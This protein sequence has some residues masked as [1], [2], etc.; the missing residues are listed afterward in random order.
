MKYLLKQTIIPIVYLIFM[1]IIA[2]GILCL[3]N[4]LTWLKIILSILNLA[5]YGFIVG[6]V[7]KKEGEDALKVRIANDVERLQIIRTGEDRP[8][9]LKEEYKAWKG[10]VVGLIVCAPLIILL[11]FHVIL[12]SINPDLVGAGVIANFIYLS[13]GAF[14]RIDNTISLMDW[15]Y[16]F[17]L[18]AVLILPLITGIPYI[19]GA[20]KIKLQQ[21]MILQKQRQIYGDDYGR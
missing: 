2:F 3:G 1:S 21:E 8:L 11:I 6:V 20:R 15:H 17:N 18:I 7:A 4:N 19:L 12:T 13:F 5:L 10:F 14:I 16:Y 9:K